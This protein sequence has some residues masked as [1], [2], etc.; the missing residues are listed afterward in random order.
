MATITYGTAGSVGTPGTL[1]YGAP[2]TIDVNTDAEL[3]LSARTTGYITV[4]ITP[5]ALISA[6][7]GVLVE[8]FR[9]Y[10]A[11]TTNFETIAAY[12][13]TMP[14]AV[15]STLESH[16]I[17][18]TPG[19]YSVKLTNLDATYTVTFSITADYLS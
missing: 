14:S 2:Y 15:A 13:Y 5:G 11:T 7:R 4:A 9:Q 18:V 12:S 16:T 10:S 17:V 3:N 1:T 8:C 19:K 6:T